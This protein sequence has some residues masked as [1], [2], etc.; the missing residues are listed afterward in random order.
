MARVSVREYGVLKRGSP[1][2]L[3]IASVNCT[4]YLHW[5]AA[6]SFAAIAIAVKAA[7]NVELKAASAWRPHRWSSRKEYEDFLLRNY[8]SLA[9]G[10]RWL[11]FDSPH[12]T[13]LALDLGVGGL[14]PTRKTIEQQRRQ[15]L[16]RWL[17]K[18]AEDH[19]WHPYQAE[20]WHWE[21]PMDSAQY[22]A[23][24]GPDSG[25]PSADT[26]AVSSGPDDMSCE[27]DE[28]CEEVEEG[29]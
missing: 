16:H 9:E 20:P 23:E 11:A 14:W 10:R 26:G 13:G 8:G 3:P 22:R 17:V 18:H 28:I 12:E 2:L 7:L 24:V 5:R 19:G 4:Q 6:E 25:E 21:F 1:L 15:P 29:T 27:S